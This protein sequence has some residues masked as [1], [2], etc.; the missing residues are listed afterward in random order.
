MSLRSPHPVPN[1]P[2]PAE[3]GLRATVEELAAIERPPCSPGERRAA[4]LIARR[5]RALGC[6]AEVEEEPAFSS[7]AR[8]VGALAVLGALAGLAGG[9]SPVLGT[10]G[11]AVAAAGL[12]DEISY[13]RQL[14]RRVVDRR[15]TACNVVA[16]LGDARAP[17]T[18]VVM[19]H[20]DA[21]PSGLIF[22]QRLERRLARRFPH[23]VERMTENPPLWW[24]AMAGPVLAALG[25]ATGSAR[26]RRT[27]A[28]LSALTAAAMADI[29]SR[30]AVPGANDNLSGVAVLIA[31]AEA[32]RER[33]VEGLRVVLLSAGA[34][35]ALQEGIRGFARR[36]FPE[37]P[38]ESTWFLNL[39]TVGSGR[40]VMLDAE[41]PLRMERYDAAFGDLVARCARELGV[42]LLRGLRSRNSTDGVV[43]NRYGYPTVCLVSV[44]EDKLLP[45][46][47]LPSDLPEHVDYRCVADA[48]Q[49][50]E[51]VVRVLAEG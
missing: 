35:E 47:H 10:L 36:H 50:A 51:A 17:R 48:A 43:P 5:L 16:E 42:T 9:R 26:V 8:P 28:V 45:H 2:R 33:P 32:L 21:A 20:H 14:A 40:L 6:R 3:S 15:R 49:L 34:E 37:L 19:A 11:G 38:R 1:V 22:D 18:L 41:G 25:S 23:V 39:D 13:G 31:L 30:R 7:Y 4:H 27:G 46:Y 12:A 29:A 24:A 44:D